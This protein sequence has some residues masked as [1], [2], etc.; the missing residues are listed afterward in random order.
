MNKWFCILLILSTSF[1]FSQ[2]EYHYLV[3]FKYKNSAF[4]INNPGDYLSIKSISRRDAYNVQI[5]STDLPINQNYIDSVKQYSLSVQ[6]QSKWH[7]CIVVSTH[8]ESI[9]DSLIGFSFV[10]SVQLIGEVVSNKKNNDKLD[11]GLNEKQIETVNINFAHNL[12]YTGKGVEIAVIDAGFSGVSSN[13]FFDSLFINNQIKST[14]NFINNQPVNYSAHG[15]GT[16][17]ASV[18][19]GNI[20]GTYVGSAPGSNYHL[21]VTED[22]NQ[23]NK[24][25]EFHLVEALEYCD[26]AGI[27]LINISLGYNTFDDSRF[28]H[29]KEELTGDSTLLNK[30]CNMAWRKGAFIVTSAGNSGTD[31]WGVVTVPANADSVFTV[32]A[33]DVNEQYAG[34]S[35]RG[36]PHINSTLK[37]NVVGVGKHVYIVKENGTVGMSNGTSFSSPQI[38]GLVSCL[39][40]AFPGKKNWELKEA[41]EYS[42]HNSLTPDSLIGHGIPNFENAYLYLKNDGFSKKTTYVT[43]YPNPSNGIFTV[44]NHLPIIE[45]NLYDARGKKIMRSIPNL[46]IAKLNVSNLSSGMYYLQT[47]DEN[48]NETIK[49]EV[50]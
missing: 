49:V 47:V 11:Y 34:F 25:E 5:D 8:V 4:S 29:Q 30:A 32:G 21:L 18:L 31:F 9:D 24:I 13:A 44:T 40:E 27:D 26:S 41:I 35:S 1:V 10:K 20:S 36:N 14:Y 48:G 39:M 38:T 17:V 50:L 46:E 19:G 33:V 15:H 3:K 22:I 43:V 42:S 23:E 16:S 7:N 12:D 28:S 2:T 6:A 37:P 45:L